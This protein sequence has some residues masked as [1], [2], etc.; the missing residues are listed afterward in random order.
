MSRDRSPGVRC[1]AFASLAPL[2]NSR[3]GRL[4]RRCDDIGGVAIQGFAC[5]V[6]VL[7]LSFLVS[8][9]Q[10]DLSGRLALKRGS[11]GWAKQQV[12]F[13]AVRL[14]VEVGDHLDEPVLAPWLDETVGEMSEFLDNGGV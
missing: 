4:W 13:G 11:G 9:N 14:V 3:L 7:S 10:R 1:A 6:I 5:S 12:E 8:R 2:R